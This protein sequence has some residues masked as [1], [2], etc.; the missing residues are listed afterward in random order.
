MMKMQVLVLAAM[1]SF[2]LACAQTQVP[3]STR[4]AAPGDAA[5]AKPDNSVECPWLT[6]VKYPWL[7]CKTDAY[8]NV[9]FDAAPTILGASQMPEMSPYVE[10][11]T[12]IGN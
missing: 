8:G 11:K 7:E 3:A 9:V 2:T 1:F 4:A 6:R 5:E 10:S 12:Y